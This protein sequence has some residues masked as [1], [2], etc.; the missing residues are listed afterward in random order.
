MIMSMLGSRRLNLLRIPGGGLSRVLL[1]LSMLL[2]GVIV[3]VYAAMRR[4]TVY[5]TIALAVLLAV[6]GLALMLLVA[7]ATRARLPFVLSAALLSYL[8]LEPFAQLRRIR[9][10]LVVLNPMFGF[11]LQPEVLAVA[12]I[13]LLLP[14]TARPRVRV[15]VPRS[16]TLAHMLLVL[17]ALLSVIPAADRS[18]ALETSVM[19]YILP[20]GFFYMLLRLDPTRRE[21]VLLL[22]L[23]VVASTVHFM[24]VIRVYNN[25][26]GLFHSLN[27]YLNNRYSE[28]P[29]FRSVSFGHS[30]DISAFVMMVYPAALLLWLRTQRRRAYRLL[31]FGC[32]LV[33]FAG[34][35]LSFSRFGLLLAPWTVIVLLGAVHRRTAISI[36]IVVLIG[37]SYYMV[38]A[39]PN[40]SGAAQVQSNYEALLDSRSDAGLGPRLFLQEQALRILATHPL[41]GVG[42]DQSR[43]VLTPLFFSNYPT[44]VNTNIQDQITVTAHNLL[45][46]TAAEM[47]LIGLAGIALVFWFVAAMGLRLRRL[48]RESRL[49]AGIIWWCMGPFLAYTLFNANSFYDNHFAVYGLLFWAYL[50]FLV[51]LM[52]RDRRGECAENDMAF[53]EEAD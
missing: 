29:G 19:S 21:I 8:P 3:A 6:C 9:G 2:C 35:L 11:L 23:V 5:G 31:L 34:L 53:V 13:A 42:L 20:I 14:L 18:V 48:R 10:A 7:Q 1:V 17:A 41:V 15:I 32:T 43:M 4:E 25:V 16:L 12:L 22:S 51:I 50:A 39:K 27:G 47:G 46:S 37:V 30:N 28:N 45:V 40:L 36:A 49:L 24:N 52:N 44:L 26:F 38:L 33:L